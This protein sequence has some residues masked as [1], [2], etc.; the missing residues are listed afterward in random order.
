MSRPCSGPIEWATLVAYWAGDLEAG[1]Q[2]AGDDGVI[3]EMS[4]KKRLAAAY[5]PHP[6]RHFAILDLR[7][8]GDETEGVAVWQAR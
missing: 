4:G 8:A 2:D 7:D 3:G 1:E 6:P 5:F